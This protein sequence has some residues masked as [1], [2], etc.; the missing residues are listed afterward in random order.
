MSGLKREELAAVAGISREYYVRL[1]QGR[2]HKIS[3]Q[4]IESLA[5]ALRLGDDERA[6][7]HRLARLL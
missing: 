7:F 4:V 2:G 3:S 6:Y 1:E 5:R